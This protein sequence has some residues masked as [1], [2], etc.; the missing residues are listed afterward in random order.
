MLRVAPKYLCDKHLMAEHREMHSIASIMSANS[1]AS[2]TARKLLEGKIRKGLVETHRVVER[3]N[4]LAAEMV[5][6]RMKHATPIAQFT[7]P[8]AGKFRG[9][10]LDEHMKKCFDCRQQTADVNASEL[11][12]R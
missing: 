9:D 5:Q 1:T 7:A 3:H 4:E 12:S 10:L 11:P 2:I 8:I 6:R